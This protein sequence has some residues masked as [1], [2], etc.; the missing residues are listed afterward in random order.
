M[1]FVKALEIYRNEP[2]EEN[3][4]L[5]AKELLLQADAQ[6]LKFRPYFSQMAPEELLWGKALVSLFQCSEVQLLMMSLNTK[7]VKCLQKRQQ[8]AVQI[9]SREYA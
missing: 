3:V 7:S 1:D 8:P 6:G 9:I 2:T 4:Q 5:L